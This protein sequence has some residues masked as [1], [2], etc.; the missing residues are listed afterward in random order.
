MKKDKKTNKIKHYIKEHKKFVITVLILLFISIAS[1][2]FLTISKNLDD[3]KIDINDIRNNSFKHT[4]KDK[5]GSTKI[6]MNFQE[7]PQNV[8]IKYTISSNEEDV[9]D[10]V[11]ETEYSYTVGYDKKYGNI[12]YFTKGKVTKL[13]KYKNSCIYDINE[14]ELTYC[15]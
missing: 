8:V 11:N 14:N 2:C 3:P 13:Y 4:V 6:E 1:T 9:D 12:I 10:I 15:K 5:Y 7:R